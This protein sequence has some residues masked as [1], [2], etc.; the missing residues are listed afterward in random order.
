MTSANRVDGV[1][2]LW[3]DR[4]F[5]AGNRRTSAA[6]GGP[7]TASLHDRAAWVRKRLAATVKSRAPQVMV[8]VT[9]GGRGMGPIAAHLR[10]ISKSGQLPIEDDRGVVREG[11]EALQDVVSQWRLGGTR[12]PDRS[13]RREAFNIMLSMPEGT[14]TT[15]LKQAVREFAADELARHRYVMVLHTHQANPHVHLSVRAEGRDGKRLNPRKEDLRRWREVFAEKLRG[16]GIEAEASSRVTRGSRHHN[17]RLWQIKA[18]ER[19]EGGASPSEGDNVKLTPSRRQVAL[20]WVEIANAL[21]TS[22]DAGDRELARLVVGYARHLPGVRSKSPEQA[23]QRT[24]PGV[25]RGGDRA[26]APSTGRTPQ[27]PDWER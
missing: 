21:A 24:L 25:S 4:L 14:N 22:D 17:E 11:Q 3:G 7:R 6:P 5:Y 12:I 26:P 2:V 20:A 15:Y 19:G 1:L 27:G 23:A 10:Y 18:R 8:K 13:E 16:W 9:G